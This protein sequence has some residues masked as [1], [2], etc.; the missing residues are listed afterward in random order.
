MYTY[1][2]IDAYMVYLA[3]NLIV[4]YI[5]YQVES[6]STILCIWMYMNVYDSSILSD[7]QQMLLQDVNDMLWNPK[8]HFGE[9]KQI[10]I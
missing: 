1:A 8:L 9:E 7:L 2:Y 5:L 3:Y 4:D 6:D 10:M